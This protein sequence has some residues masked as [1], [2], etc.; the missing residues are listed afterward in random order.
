MAFGTAFYGESL[1]EPIRRDV[2]I[3]RLLVLRYLVSMDKRVDLSNMD[4]V[5]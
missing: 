3:E 5:T 4:M 2:L 1:N